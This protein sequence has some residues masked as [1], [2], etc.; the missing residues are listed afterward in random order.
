MIYVGVNKHK[1]ELVIT[2]HGKKVKLCKTDK[3]IKWWK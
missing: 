1:D 3:D 2:V